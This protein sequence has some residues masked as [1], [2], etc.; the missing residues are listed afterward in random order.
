[1]FQLVYCG[2]KLFSDG[3]LL[4]DVL[5][6]LVPGAFGSFGAARSFRPPRLLQL[7]GRFGALKQVSYALLMVV[8]KS[9]FPFILLLLMLCMIAAMLTELFGR[10]HHDGHTKRDYLSRLGI[11]V[12]T[13]FQIM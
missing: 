6:M 1:M 3:R 11:K 4:L 9:T 5:T 7:V 13:L 10:M 8:P 12:F 2:F